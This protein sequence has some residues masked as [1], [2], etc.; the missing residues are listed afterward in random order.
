MT[1][2]LLASGVLALLAGVALTILASVEWLEHGVLPNVGVM[3]VSLAGVFTFYGLGAIACGFRGWSGFSMPAPVR[4][5]VAG[6]ILFLAFCALEF[7]DGLIRQGGRVFYWTSVLFLPALL[8]L[9]GLVSERRWAW[10]T[11]RGV[12]AIFTL[13]FVGFIAVIPFADLHGSDGPVPWEGRVY[14][15]G[16][17]LI[18]TSI[19]AYAFHLLGRAPARD[20][21]GMSRRA[22]PLTQIMHGAPRPSTAL[23]DGGVC[24]IKGI[25]N[26]LRIL[27]TSTR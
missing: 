10:W 9:Y 8:L 27:V 16:V 3:V 2:W 12:T 1:R 14:M 5:A 11:A 19:S 17:S 13:W 23:R 6:N 24:C 26:Y 22:E 7:S 25:R 18:F 15:V 21:F 20:Y 4:A